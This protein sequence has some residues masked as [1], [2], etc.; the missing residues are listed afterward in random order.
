MKTWKQAIDYY[1]P[2]KRDKRLAFAEFIQRIEELRCGDDGVCEID[3]E[4]KS[5]IKRLLDE[6]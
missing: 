5:H 6:L 4:Q 3:D 1:K 2:G